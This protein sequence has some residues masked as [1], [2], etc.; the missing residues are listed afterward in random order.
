MTQIWTPSGTPYLLQHGKQANKP[1][2]PSRRA[3]LRFGVFHTAEN[4]PD[5]DPPDLGAE[6]V[7]K[8][9]ATTERASWHMTV[10]SDS[11]IW[12]LPWSYTAWHVRNY[13]SP[14][15]GVE[16]AMTASMWVESP[17]AWRMAILENTARVVAAANV[18]AGIPPII[19]TR[20]EIDAGKWGWTFHRLLDP[21]RRSDP[22]AAF[23]H[24][25]VLNRAEELLTAT[26]PPPT[27][28]AE[29]YATELVQEGIISEADDYRL[30]EPATRAELFAITSRL[31]N[32]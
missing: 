2:Y 19:R 23:P 18:I 12:M 1:W 10:D 13:N 16:M 26:P 31:L 11:I 15:L 17:L 30:D 22:G 3:P 29:V 4:L 27:H 9:G 14:S 25:W 20:A 32:R 28:W 6:A 7:A 21:T 5:F 8:Y 24:E